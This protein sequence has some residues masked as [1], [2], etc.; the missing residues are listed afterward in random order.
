MTKSEILQAL[1]DKL[2]MTRKQVSEF[3]EALVQM[4]YT[5]TKKKANS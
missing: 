2:G 1:A 5:T 3:M 4:A